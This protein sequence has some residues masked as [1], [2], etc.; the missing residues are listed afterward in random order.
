[1]AIADLDP[2]AIAEARRINPFDRDRPASLG[3]RTWT[4]LG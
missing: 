3:G 1:M 4:T 2:E